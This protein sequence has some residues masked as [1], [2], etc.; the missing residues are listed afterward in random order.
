MATPFT[1]RSLQTHLLYLLQHASLPDMVLALGLLFLP[2]R[3]EVHGHSDL[4]LYPTAACPHPDGLGLALVGTHCW[5]LERV[6]GGLCSKSTTDGRV[7]E[8]V[9]LS[10]ASARSGKTSFWQPVLRDSVSLQTDPCPPSLEECRT[11]KRTSIFEP[12][13]LLTTWP[14]PLVLVAWRNG[15]LA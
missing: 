8:I 14:R 15:R 6:Q 9:L 11:E 10:V 7:Y 12:K 3:C 2:L 1:L 4:A 13:H 5:G